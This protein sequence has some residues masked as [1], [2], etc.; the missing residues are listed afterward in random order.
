[1]DSREIPADV[2]AHSPVVCGRFHFCLI[3]DLHPQPERMLDE[4][5]R[6]V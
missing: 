3:D 6:L 1:M 2:A 4:K 5:E